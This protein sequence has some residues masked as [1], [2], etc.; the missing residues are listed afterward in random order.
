VIVREPGRDKWLVI[1]QAVVRNPRL[2]H[3]ARGI[4]CLLLSM[5][6][7]WRVNAEWVAMHGSEGRDAVRAALKELEEA[8][9]IIRHKSQDAFGRWYTHS[10]VYEQPVDR[11][12][13]NWATE[14]GFPG[15]GKPGANRNTY[16][17]VSTHLVT[18]MTKQS[19]TLLCT[20]CG[21]AGQVVSPTNNINQC[22]T[23]NGDGLDG[24]DR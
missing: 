7:D 5:P 12:V 21:G 24:T 19:C 8:G 20:T 3:R 4:L 14:D 1:D 2:S 16:K 18:D 15:V 11:G 10:V 13:D 23:C 6:D 22:P 17:E 9:H